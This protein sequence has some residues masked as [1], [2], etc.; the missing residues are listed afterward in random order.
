MDACLQLRY[1]NDTFG[2]L[3][4]DQLNIEDPRKKQIK[5]TGRSTYV[6]TQM[7]IIPTTYTPQQTQTVFGACGL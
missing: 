3:I 6:S 5:G 4:F 1:H 2:N 7:T